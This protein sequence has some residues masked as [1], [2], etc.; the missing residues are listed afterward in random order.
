MAL[1][2][3]LVLW[4]VGMAGLALRRLWGYRLGM[5]VFALHMILV[6]S[7]CLRWLADSRAPLR[8][9][10]GLAVWPSLQLVF[11]DALVLIYLLEHRNMFLTRAFRATWSGVKNKYR[12]TLGLGGSPGD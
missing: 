10:L 4:L 8:M 9:A 7:N 11:A 2:L 6:V 5:L 12:D 1:A 3:W